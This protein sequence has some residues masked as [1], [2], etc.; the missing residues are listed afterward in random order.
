MAEQYTVTVA[1]PEVDPVVAAAL[2]GRAAEGR[3][4]VL[5]FDSQELPQFFESEVQRKL[6][7]G[8]ALVLCGVEVVHIDWDGRLVRPQLMENLRHFFGEVRWFSAAPW[9]PEDRRA[10]GH[11]IG[12]ERLVVSEAAESVAALV[13]RSLGAPEDDYEEGLARFAAGRM[14]GDET[15]WGEPLRA[16]LTSLKADRYALAEAAGELMEE[17]IEGLLDRH[18]EGARAVEEE[19]RRFA[20]EEA[21]DP[22][23]MG[24]SRLVCVALPP[25]RQCFWAEISAYAREEAEADVSL[26]RMLG[27]PTVVLARGSEFRADLREWARYVTDLM[28]AA[29]SVGAR[30]EVVPLVVDGLDED[31]GLQREL[32]NLLRDGAHLLRQ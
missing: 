31:P 25:D 13:R 9:R 3:T 8:Y 2:A 11:M 5:I 22:L 1:A 6:P 26:C 15:D 24:E 32:L 29:R 4:E 10:V 12:D 17:N 23:R 18:L 28:P 14:A 7:R 20:G 21:G 27:R 30:E 19:N 16:V